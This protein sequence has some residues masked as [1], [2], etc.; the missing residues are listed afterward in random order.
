MSTKYGELDT[1]RLPDKSQVVLNGNSTL[2]YTFKKNAPREVWLDGEAFFD[3]R[4]LDRDSVILP[5]ERFLVHVGRG[6]VE[7]LGTTFN[8]RRRRSSIEIALISGSIKL[9]I[10]HSENPDILLGPGELLISDTAFTSIKRTYTNTGNSAA[11]TEKRLLLNNPTVSEIVAYLEDTYG[12]KIVLASPA[13]AG[14]K[15]EGPILL[16]S[17]DD[18]LFVLSTVLNVGIVTVN[19]TLIIK[20]R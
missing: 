12:K 20:Q 4:H 5:G 6:T 9:H 19:D 15:V 17:L 18:A 8:I 3:V 11:W 13:L 7:V 16:D 10:D 14:K 2:R 1:L